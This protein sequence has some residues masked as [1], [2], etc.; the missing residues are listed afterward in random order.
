MKI[1]RTIAVA[2]TALALATLPGASWATPPPAQPPYTGIPVVR[3]SPEHPV[4]GPVVKAPTSGRGDLGHSKA[5][6]ATSTWRLTYVFS[7]SR[8]GRFVVSN[9]AR[10]L[11]QLLVDQQGVAGS[12]SV[13]EPAGRYALAV[14]S[15]CD[16]SMRAG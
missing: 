12:G 13:W 8:P 9:N 14:S 7:C 2:A 3:H 15:T 4:Q 5:F 6:T 16:W 11:T 1:T 10:Y